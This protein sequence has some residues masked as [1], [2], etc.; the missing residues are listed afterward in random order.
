MDSDENPIQK[1]ERLKDITAKYRVLKFDPECVRKKAN[2]GTLADANFEKWYLEHPENMIDPEFIRSLRLASPKL[3]KLLKTIQYLDAK[4]ER[5]HG[6]K[7]KHFIFSD[8]KSS[9]K[10]LASGLIASGFRVGVK[11]KIKHIK[12]RGWNVEKTVGD[13]IEI[14]S[15][16]ELAAEKAL[17]GCI[18]HFDLMASG[19]VFS[20]AMTVAQ[21]KQLFA[22]FNARDDS[23]V[24][25]RNNHGEQVRIIVMDNGFKEGV[26]LFDVKYVHIFEPQVTMADTKQVIGRGTRTCGQKGLTF[27]PERGWPLHVYVYDLDLGASKSGFLEADSA[28]DLYLKALNI[29]L[30]LF[31][32]HNEM[33]QLMMEGSVDYELNKAV[34]EFK[35]KADKE[36]DYSWSRSASPEIPFNLQEPSAVLNEAEYI[37]EIANMPADTNASTLLNELFKGQYFVDG[38]GEYITN[39]YRVVLDYDIVYIQFKSVNSMETIAHV[40]N[41]VGNALLLDYPGQYINIRN[42]NTNEEVAFNFEGSSYS[43]VDSYASSKKTPQYDSDGNII[44]SESSSS[45]SAKESSDKEPSDFSDSHYEYMAATFPYTGNGYKLLNK[46]F[47]SKLSGPGDALKTDFYLVKSDGDILYLYVSSISDIAKIQTLVKKIGDALKLGPDEYGISLMDKWGEEIA[48]ED[49]DAYLANQALRDYDDVEEGEDDSNANMQGK[50][51]F[52]IR[53]TGNIDSEDALVNWLTQ[54]TPLKMEDTKDMYIAVTSNEGNTYNVMYDFKTVYHENKMIDL[55]RALPE[56]M[57]KKGPYKVE[58]INNSMEYMPKNYWGGVRGGGASAY[59]GGAKIKFTPTQDFVSNFFTPQNPIKGMLLNHSVGTGK[60]CTAIA[61]ATGSF[62]P[63]GY[64]ILW[65]TRTTLKND[66]WKNMFDMVCHHGLMNERNMPTAQ[67]ERMKLLSKSWSIRP[68]SY[69]QFTNL[70]TKANSYY[71]RLVKKNGAID[72]LRKTLLVIDEA[73][74][75]FGGNDL[76]SIERPD[77]A[78]LHQALMSSYLIS[79]DDSVRLLLM[80]ATPITKDPLELVKLLNLCKM[81]DEQIPD[82]LGQFADAYLK[83]DG[84]FSEAGRR[85]FL[86]DIAGHISYLN[87]EKDARQFSQPVL[88]HIKVPFNDKAMIRSFDKQLVSRTHDIETNKLKTEVATKAYEIEEHFKG[89]DKFMVPLGTVCDEIKHGPLKKKCVTTINKKRAE[90]VRSVKALAKTRRGQI[91]D[92]KAQVKTL[93]RSKKTKLASIKAETQRNALKYKDTYGKSAYAKLASCGKVDTENVKFSQVVAA[94]PDVQNVDSQIMHWNTVVPAD[95]L[96]MAARIKAERKILTK[97]RLKTLR[98][99]LKER[100]SEHNYEKKQHLKTLKKERKVLVKGHYKTLTNLKKAAVKQAREYKK[101]QD[102]LKKLARKEG[103]VQEII[104]SEIKDL[105]H[106]YLEE[107]PNDERI[108]EIKLLDDAKA[109]K[110]AEKEAKKAE[111]ALEKEA[112]ALEKE[113]KAVAMAEKKAAMAL[114]KEAKAQAMAEKK[115]AMALAKEAKAQAMAEKKEEKARAMTLKKA[116]A[117]AKKANKTRKNKPEPVFGA[118]TKEDNAIYLNNNYG[119]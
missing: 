12:P 45:D 5:E 4:D 40:A 18:G 108:K 37:Y 21:K 15:A 94:K 60:T 28:F 74:K 10:L 8:I 2:V 65:V 70:V 91:K 73:H 106:K 98:A 107:L 93:T 11:P 117:A 68:I 44:H 54:N 92:I 75:L 36:A 7:F 79:G 57:T 71:A 52:Q 115:A 69:K 23:T 118:F 42:L 64:T 50:M 85:K 47:G 43:T 38:Q 113:A 62:E 46:A 86:D 105:V 111:K 88:H 83:E 27:D 116:E 13:G 58:L 67:S 89:F 95:I 20:K 33:E 19:S 30:R 63:Q 14:L 26:D 49:V 22:R 78:K 97:P 17:P 48:L 102:K 1:A 72:P 81:P 55:V 99:E 35:G 82:S 51:S 76:S 61:T 114:A 3:H 53:V 84:S 101:E 6:H 31:K 87:R 56:K 9:T 59:T 32:L 77:T 16:D 29:D 24:Y 66:I 41:D 96:A 112:K 103:E 80:T 90:L 25:P 110:D 119:I 100:K 39:K 109:E 34:H 104:N